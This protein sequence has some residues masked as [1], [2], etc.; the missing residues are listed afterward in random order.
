[1][2]APVLNRPPMPT[3]AIPAAIYAALTDEWRS[4]FLVARR[5]RWMTGQYVGAADAERVLRVLVRRGAAWRF[6]AI[7]EAERE[8]FG[9]HP[10][11]RRAA[12]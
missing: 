1:M 10:L 8:A 2:S 4:P 3:G 7:T 6:K 5:A 9:R 12:P 11:Y